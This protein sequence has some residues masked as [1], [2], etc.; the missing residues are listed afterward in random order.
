MPKKSTLSLFSRLPK[1]MEDSIV[2]QSFPRLHQRCT[3]RIRSGDTKEA[4]DWSKTSVTKRLS[5]LHGNRDYLN[6]KIVQIQT[7]GHPKPFDLRVDI[8]EKVD[9]VKDRDVPVDSDKVI[10][11]PL[12][13]RSSSAT[14]KKKRSKKK[15]K[16][17]R[18]R[19]SV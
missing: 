7:R 14:K 9:D 16:R 17:S 12:K 3:M 8:I 4:L 19:R 13:G 1:E 10:F 15:K 11:T 5:D 18:K 6:S 2:R